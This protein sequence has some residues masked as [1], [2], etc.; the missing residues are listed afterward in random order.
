LSVGLTKR[1]IQILLLAV[2]F[3]NTVKNEK[4]NNEKFRAS[5]AENIS[6]KIS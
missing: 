1:H 5:R 6:Y 3:C 4:K 2:H